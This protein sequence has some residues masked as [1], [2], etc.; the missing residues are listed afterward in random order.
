MSEVEFLEE[1]DGSLDNMRNAKLAANKS[2]MGKMLI[3]WHLA[4]DVYAANKILI[5]VTIL[6]FVLTFVLIISTDWNPKP[7]QSGYPFSPEILKQL[8]P[9][10]KVN[11]DKATKK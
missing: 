9:Q 6:F 1:S 2:L 5:G 7:V 10:V 3:Q 4:N 8:P 11:I